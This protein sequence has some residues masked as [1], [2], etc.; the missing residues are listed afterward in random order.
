MDPFSALGLAAN[1]IAFVDFSWKLLSST[2]EIYKIGEGSTSDTK[3]LHI[4]VQDIQSYNGRLVASHA[5]NAALRGIITKANELSTKLLKATEKLTSSEKSRWGS[6]VVALRGVL[7]QKE[8]NILTTQLEGLQKSVVAHIQYMTLDGLSDLSRKI[9]D[10]E[11]TDRVFGIGMQKELNSLSEPVVAAIQRVINEESRKALRECMAHQSRTG[12]PLQP[13]VIEGLSKDLEELRDALRSLRDRGRE[14][15]SDQELLRGLHFSGIKDRHY[16]IDQAH[17]ETFQWIFRPTEPSNI[18]FDKWLQADSGTFFI[19]G[20][21]GSGKSTLMKFIRNAPETGARLKRWAG[22]KKMVIAHYFFWNAGP[23]L[24]KSQEGLLRSLLF[25]ILRRCHYLIPLA[26]K[27]IVDVEDFESDEDRWTK[28]QLLQTYQALVSEDFSTRFCFFVDGLDEYHDSSRNPEE[29]IQT[30]KSLQSSPNIKLCVSSRPWPAF[31]EAFGDTEWI[32]K[33]ED[34]TRNDILKYVNDKFNGSKQYRE[35]TREN[36]EY[37]NLTDEVAIRANGVF[38]WVVLVVRN[39][40]EG[41][42]NHDSVELMRDRLESFP[43]DLELFFEHM[44]NS[45][46]KIYQKLMT[47]TFQAAALSQ[48]PLLLMFYS[49]LDDVSSNRPIQEPL[50]LS[51]IKAR[52]TRMRRQLYGRSKG[53]LEVVA[54]E[55]ETRPFFQLR[56]DFLHR[57][58]RDFL[59]ESAS[60]RELF[61]NNLER[62]QTNTPLLVCRTIEAEMKLAMKQKGLHEEDLLQFVDDLFYFANLARRDEKRQVPLNVVEELIEMGETTHREAIFHCQWTTRSSGPIFLGLAAQYDFQS[63]MEKKLKN[64]NSRSSLTRQTGRP[65]LDYAL[66]PSSG[67]SIV[68]YSEAMVELLLSSGADP[69]QPY[70]NSTIWLRFVAAI[71]NRRIEADGMV[72]ARIIG[73]LVM[74]KATIDRETAAVLDSVLSPD[75]KSA[76]QDLRR[77]Q[78]FLRQFFSRRSRAFIWL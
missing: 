65:V 75:Q 61:E 78:G 52:Q 46:D 5:T 30:L 69:N 53:L 71:V 48:R 32:L 33:V 16:K 38:L 67:H 50:S 70:K 42:R 57:T 24:Q 63:Y 6:F 22:D 4:I 66:V 44:L 9:A 40:L 29:L 27:T 59:R 56:V 37:G 62:E 35:L 43:K 17:A 8:I 28:E 74:N 64:A 13:S 12:Q 60:V 10:M 1:I 2:R 45:V 20:K 58:V 36:P 34:H 3:F 55:D 68:E 77:K 51:D 23:T 7:G 11:K 26:K 39:L 18:P 15:A 54:D 47:R 72:I 31:T 73:A 19:Y 49:F 41:F 76:I 25:E 14:T 21:P